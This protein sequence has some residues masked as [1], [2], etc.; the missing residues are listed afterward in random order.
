MF[1]WRSGQTRSREPRSRIAAQDRRAMARNSRRG[2]GAYGGREEGAEHG[3][4]R[5][6]ERAD[7]VVVEARR[8]RSP[9]RLADERAVVGRDHVLLVRPPVARLEAGA[10]EVGEVAAGEADRQG[11]PVDGDDVVGRTSGCRGGSRRGRGRSSSG[12]ARRKA[13]DRG[14]SLASWNVLVGEV[15]AAYRSMNWSTP[16]AI[17]SPARRRRG[18]R[19][20][21]QAELA[22]RRIAPARGV[23]AGE[24]LGPP[25]SAW[26]LGSRRPAP[27]A[28][29]APGPRAA[30]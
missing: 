29:P 21:E 6:L 19:R 27:P 16:S 24:V 11:L 30:A 5:A 7:A 4:Q 13:A 20:G 12:R 9:R 1:G 14:G 18:E 17:T 3:D 15:V 23:Q 2:L 8:R 26:R 28:P 22:Q 10:E 25:P